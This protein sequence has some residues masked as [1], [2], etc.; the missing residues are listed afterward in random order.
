MTF[1]GTENPHLLR[2]SSIS[3]VLMITHIQMFSEKDNHV[4]EFDVTFCILAVFCHG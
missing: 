1:S 2:W 3:I 4:L